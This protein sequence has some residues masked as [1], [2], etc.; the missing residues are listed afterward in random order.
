[1]PSVGALIADSI[2]IASA[3]AIC[4][5]T[6]T[7]SPSPTASVTPPVIGAATWASSFGSAFSRTDERL[8]VQVGPHRLA[9]FADLVGLVRLLAVEGTPIF[10][11]VDRDGAD[12]ELVGRPE[13]PDGDLPAVGDKSFLQ[14]RASLPSKQSDGWRL[15]AT[16]VEGPSITP[17][18]TTIGLQEVHVHAG[19]GYRRRAETLHGLGHHD[20]RGHD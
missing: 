17:S 11:G 18:L 8:D 12:A 14:H 2:F 6:P 10:G 20:L 4:C 3:V 16:L 19:P 1:V 7:L 9:R 13:R 15:P 5:P